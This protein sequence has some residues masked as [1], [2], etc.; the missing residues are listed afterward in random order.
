MILDYLILKNIP[1]EEGE[2]L[3]SELEAADQAFVSNCTG[4]SYLESYNKT[5]YSTFPLQHLNDLFE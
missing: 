4:I 3:P 5:H 2:F 1:F